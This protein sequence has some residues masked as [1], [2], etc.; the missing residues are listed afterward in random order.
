MSRETRAFVLSSVQF[1][2]GY[3]ADLEAIGTACRERD[4]AF[5]VDATQSVCAYPID[6]RQ[7]SIDALVFSGYKWATAGYGIAVL[8]LTEELLQRRAPLVGWRSARVPYLLEND[9]LEISNTGAAHELGH[10]TFPGIFC[11]GEALRLFTEAGVERVSK[12]IDQLVSDLRDRI[13][14]LDYRIVS[15]GETGETS[16]ILLIESGNADALSAE[17]RQRDVWTTAR[18]GGL[19]VSVHAYNDESDLEAFAEA[20]AELSSPRRRL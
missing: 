11:L 12:R 16:G 18:A 13:E 9:R 14:K 20:L 19:R 15:N 5:V 2:N 10:P 1:A 7:C 17:L 3:R 6:V 8:H 4:I